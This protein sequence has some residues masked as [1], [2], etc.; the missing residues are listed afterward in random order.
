MARERTGPYP[1]PVVSAPL[2]EVTVVAQSCVGTLS[3]W[4]QWRRRRRGSAALRCS[5]RRWAV[6]RNRSLPAGCPRTGAPATHRRGSGATWGGVVWCTGRV[7]LPKGA[8]VLHGGTSRKSWRSPYR[9]AGSALPACV[10]QPLCRRRAGPHTAGRLGV[11]L[12]PRPPAVMH[13]G[14]AYTD[15]VLDRRRVHTHLAAGP[16][17]HRSFRFEG[18]VFTLRRGCHV[19]LR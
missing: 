10:L 5:R 4:G 1:H 2:T 17:G 3:V 19:V 9:L 7:G 11:F 13:S 12:H 14:V 8:R 16:L 15:D 6:S 18:P